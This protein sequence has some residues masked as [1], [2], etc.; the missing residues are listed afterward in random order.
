[1]RALLVLMGFVALAAGAV[2]TVREVVVWV[3]GGGFYHVVRWAGAAW[4]RL[5]QEWRG[6]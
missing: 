5:L 2:V 3:R 1:M 4:R 6:R